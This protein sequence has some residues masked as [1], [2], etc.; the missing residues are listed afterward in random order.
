MI[1]RVILLVGLPG[2]GKTTWGESFI[3]SNPKSVFL[4]D[5]SILTNNAREYIDNI[6]KI[7]V[8]DSNLIISDVYFCQAKVREMAISIIKEIFP[9]SLLEIIFF[10]N[11]P[12][13]CLANVESRMKKGDDRKVS[14]MIR[15]LS[16]E[17]QI[18]QNE[19]VLMVQN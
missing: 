5:I 2:S 17:Y 14:E 8:D 4:D 15:I 11:S 7:N 12:Q 13:K 19:I 18:P 16:K 6:K 10:E 9:N 3:K 1:N